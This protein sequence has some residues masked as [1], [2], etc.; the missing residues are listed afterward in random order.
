MVTLYHSSRGLSVL[1]LGACIHQTNEMTPKLQH[2]SPNTHTHDTFIYSLITFQ[3]SVVVNH[4]NQ[5]EW[6]GKMNV[7]KPGDARENTFKCSSEQELDFT[8]SQEL[9][10]LYCN[11]SFVC[12]FNIRG[13]WKNGPIGLYV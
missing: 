11:F 2:P 6:Q 13:K 12:V 9:C 10:M 4:P 1:A 3:I 7:V 5:F 8:L